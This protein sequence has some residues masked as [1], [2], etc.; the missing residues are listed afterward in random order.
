VAQT[1]KTLVALAILVASTALALDEEDVSIEKLGRAYRIHMA[2]DVPASVDQIKA[3]LTDY[4]HPSRLSSAVTAREVLGRQDGAVRVRTEFRDCVVFFCKTMI[5][6][7]D[8]SVSA[9]EVRADVVA[10]GSD[11]RNGFLRWSIN[12]LG[13]G[14]S[15]VVFN[16]V[17]E[18]DF[19]VPPLIGGFL[20]RKAL[21]KQAL[22]TAENLVSEAPREPLSGYEE[23]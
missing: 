12:G 2:F 14:R 23:Q 17:M 19:F 6:V 15:H 5:L 3:V 13:D 16:A 1:T 22:A 10:E 20:I 9:T 11:F 8:V 21:G 7:H 18:P 4:A